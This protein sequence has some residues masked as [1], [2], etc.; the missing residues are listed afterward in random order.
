MD[1]CTNNSS[2]NQQL[3]F[4]ST[5]ARGLFYDTILN[6]NKSNSPELINFFVKCVLIFFH[7]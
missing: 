2:L 7:T 6:N 5:Y 3:Y 4:N 1:I